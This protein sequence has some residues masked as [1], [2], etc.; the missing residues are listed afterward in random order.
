MGVMIIILLAFASKSPGE[1]QLQVFHKKERGYGRKIYAP[2]P[3]SRNTAKRR[4]VVRE[5]GCIE[6]Q[7]RIPPDWI[8][9]K[10]V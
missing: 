7:P 9:T 3:K 1:I 6:D 4:I 5:Q 8:D 2:D 10:Y